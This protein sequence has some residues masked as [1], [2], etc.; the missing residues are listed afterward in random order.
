MTKNLM[1]PSLT[2]I[3][4]QELL[5][6]FVLVLTMCCYTSSRTFSRCSTPML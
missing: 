5:D 1:T 3:G 2:S 6:G 4:N